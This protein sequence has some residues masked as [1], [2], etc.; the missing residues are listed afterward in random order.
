MLRTIL[1]LNAICIYGSAIAQFEADIASEADYDTLYIKSYTDL[2]AVKLY[3]VTKSNEIRHVDDFTNQSINYKPNDKFNIGIGFNYKW[4]GLD[5]AFNVLSINDDDDQFGKTDRF[6][7]QSNVYLRKF[8]M[9]LNVQLYEGYY[10]NNPNI[11]LPNWTSDLPNPQRSDIRT[12]TIGANAF[13]IFKNDKFSYR[14]TFIFNERQKKS[15]GSWLAGSYF[16]YFTFDADSSIVPT[17]LLT[18]FNPDVDFRKT[19][20]VQ[21]GAAGG[22]AHTFVIGKKFFFSL[23]LAIGLGPEF[24]SSKDT[25]NDQKRTDVLLTG[26]ITAR[27]ALGF[28]SDKTF[29][30]IT[31]VADSSGGGGEDNAWL[32]HS[33][34]N[35]RLFFG[36]R[37]D[38]SRWKKSKSTAAL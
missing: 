11:Y 19:R 13:Y 10:V 2:L 21:F 20:F 38:V 26:K 29:F 32:Q 1:I 16:S 35:V 30:G 18:T 15:A 23:T 25:E 7:V 3:G 5:L 22:Y 27:S 14:S 37:F 12:S 9:D 31:S 24:R 17:D 4:L 33:V 6:D 8:A 28:N 36:K 34:N